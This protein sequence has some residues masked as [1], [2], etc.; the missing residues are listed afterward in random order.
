MNSHVLLIHCPDEKGLLHKISGVLYKNDLNVISNGEFVEKNFSHFFMRTEFSGEFDREQLLKELHAAL[1]EEVNIKL[2]ERKKK[3]IIIMATKEHHCL[4]DILI[5]HAFGE[6]NAN[7]LCVIS[8]YTLLQDMT[9]RFR[10]PFYHV[11]AEH[12]TREA[13]E[14]EVLSIVRRYNPEFLILAKYMRILSPDF[15]SHFPNKII[16]IHHSFLP[17]FVGANP[18]NQ[19]YQR[20]VKIIGATAHFVNDNLDEG[21]IIAQNVITVDHTQNAKEMAQEGRDVEKIVLAK[22]LRLVL[23]DHVFV[24]KNKTFIF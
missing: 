8:N 17:A 6:L 12:K 16:N 20:V 7:I 23:N 9:E 15:V 13:H 22:S 2:T 10:I 4:S 14:Q 19:A 11:D 21:P 1:P 3:D 24:F 18:Y 5:R